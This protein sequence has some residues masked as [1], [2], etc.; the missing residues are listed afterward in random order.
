MKLYYNGS[1]LTMD[2]SCPRVEAILTENGKIL[3]TGTKNDLWK[4][5]V[6]LED[7]Q[8][9]TLMPGFV[10]GHSHM[11][12]VGFQITQNCDLNG[13]S[14]FEDLMGRIRNFIET[15]KPTTG[16]PLL[17]RGYD[18]AI[19]REGLHPT[20]KL[21]D[22][23]GYDGP[24][25]CVHISGHVAVYNTIAME[26]AGVL[27]ADY[28]VP[29]GG[30]AGRDAQG[31]LNGYFEETARAPMQKL[32]VR[33]ES[34]QALQAALEAAQEAY[35]R[36]GY[37]TV[38]EGS[39]N[40]VMRLESLQELAQEGVLQVDTVVYQSAAQELHPAALPKTYENHLKLG[41]VKLFL[42][43]S[44]QARTAWMR[45]PYE[46]DPDYCGY[47]IRTDEEVEQCIRSATDHGMQIMA[48][49]NGD[50]A[51]EQFLRVWE[52]V[53]KP[54]LR[55]VMIHAQ[56]VGEDQLERMA[57]CGMMASFFVGHCWYWGDTHLQ[58]MG[59]RGMRISPAAKA[60]AL[61][62]P[63]S[64]HQDSPVTS[65]DMLHSIWCAVNRVTRTGVQLDKTYALDVYDALIAA[66]GGAAY[67]YFEEEQKGCLKSG[68][69]ADFV[70]LDR[71]P[72]AVDPMEIRNIRVLKTIK[73]DR[74]LYSMKP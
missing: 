58:N 12:S 41:G 13:C 11:V 7:L 37:T 2:K 55:P 54:G 15:R 49:C 57:C 10:D 44:P 32:F 68:A 70:V 42:D 4:K 30:A 66:T 19:M 21:L 17:C 72:T 53:G 5:D 48:H 20:A 62:I 47:G 73:E 1:I 9:S 74:V 25:C 35:I 6:E 50:M 46:N 26:Q 3:K 63:F 59:D 39:A 64:L 23:L 8:G 71:D 61:G 29:A 28:C 33:D 51:C 56:F 38:Q 65:P 36:N 52:Q 40:T 16:T 27:K 60:L 67:G 69:V 14:D 34:K 22:S 31:K 18:P 24:I 45:R 43:G